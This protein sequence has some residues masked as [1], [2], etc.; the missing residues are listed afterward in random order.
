MKIIL[1]R[2]GFELL[3]ECRMPSNLYFFE[4]L[5]K[6]SGMPNQL[7]SQIKVDASDFSKKNKCIIR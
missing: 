6:E 2:A 1:K 5:A 7:I 4:M 3:W